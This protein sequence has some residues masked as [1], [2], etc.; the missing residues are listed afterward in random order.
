MFMRHRSIKNGLKIRSKRALMLSTTALVASGLLALPAQAEPANSWDYDVVLGG[1][2]L[3]DTSLAGTTNLTVNSGNGFVEGNADIYSG[4]TVNV[5]GDSGATFAY[6]D[7]RS[8]ISTTINGNLNS[9]M[10]IVVIDNNGVF[11]SSGAKVDVQSL[12]T[13]SAN[14]QVNDV[15]N[16]GDLTFKNVKIWW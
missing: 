3:K 4:H 15:M 10:K 16:G 6:R 11:Y 5:T 7:N 8:S 9:N 14:V 2:V 1:S 13:T 12:V